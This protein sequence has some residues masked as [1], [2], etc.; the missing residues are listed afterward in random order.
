M[1]ITL[2]KFL[3]YEMVRQSGMTNMFDL[4]TVSMLAKELEDTELSRVEVM[5]IMAHY[6]EYKDIFNKHDE[7]DTLFE[8]MDTDI[9]I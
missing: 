7:E 3:A 6:D 9:T 1:Q 4:K 8:N 5:N 2:E